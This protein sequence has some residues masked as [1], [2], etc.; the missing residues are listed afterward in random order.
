MV[1]VH[2]CP[3]YIYG[4]LAQLVARCSDIAK[5]TGSNPVSP[6][7]KIYMKVIF[8]NDNLLVV[9]KEAGI[10]VYT[11]KTSLQGGEK[12]LIDQIL[13]KFPEL[14]KVGESPRYGMIHRLDKETSGIIL[15]AKNNESLNFF[16]KKFKE[17]RVQKKY[18]L[19]VNGIIKEDKG[20]IEGLMARSPKDKRKQKIYL[21][22]EPSGNKNLRESK[23]E[24]KV[25]QRFKDLPSTTFSKRNGLL[26]LP[27]TT[28]SK[29]NGLLG[30]PSTTFSKRNGAGFTLVEASPKTGRKHQLRVHFVHLGHP[31]AGDKLYSFKNQTIIPELKRQFLHASQL[32]INLVNG[33]TKEFNSELPKDIKEILK[34]LKL[35]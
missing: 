28:F 30:L 11:E 31:I 25:L 6:T 17:K 8:E 13:E 33:K 12:T 3:L 15:I 20:I 19:L 21:Q 29:R 9:E 4:R 23:T 24:Y 10:I 22:N 14:E 7:K 2:P 1:R 5:V 34:K 27:S 35:L 26:G 16:Q 32:K 18:I